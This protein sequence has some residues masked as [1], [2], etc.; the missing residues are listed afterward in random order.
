M[1]P[2]A[3]DSYPR[4]TAMRSILSAALQIE[5]SKGCPRLLLLGVIVYASRLIVSRVASSHR[6]RARKNDRRSLPPRRPTLQQD[7]L[8]LEHF[9]A[10]H[11]ARGGRSYRRNQAS[12]L[13]YCSVSRYC[14]Y[15][16]VPAPGAGTGAPQVR[17]GAQRKMGAIQGWPAGQITG[18]G[19]RFRRLF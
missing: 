15:V 7:V 10:E 18:I 17:V 13:W 9:I 3:C 4:N 19:R 12:K 16:G 8:A 6:F 14:T 1:P 5:A 2:T 11:R